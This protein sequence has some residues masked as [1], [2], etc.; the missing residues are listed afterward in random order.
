MGWGRWGFPLPAPSEKSSERGWRLAMAARQMEW[1]READKIPITQVSHPNLVHDF[2]ASQPGLA[3]VCHD[4][5]RYLIA[6]A[7]QLS[8]PGFGGQ[9][10][11]Q[12]ESLYQDSVEL[13]RARRAAKSPSGTALTT[14]KNPPGCDEEYALRDPNFG[15][16]KSSLIACGFVQG[17][18]VV[19]GPRPQHYSCIDYV[20]W[21]LSDESCWLPT[22]VRDVLTEGLATWA[23]WIWSG[24]ER[25]LDDFGFEGASFTGLLME[26]LMEERVSPSVSGFLLSA[27]ARKDLIHRLE[28]SAELLGLPE[29]G[30]VLADR[31]LTAG[32]MQSYL[33]SGKKK[34]KRKK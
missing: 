29:S 15:R 26:E 22:E 18:G 12:I 32:F 21:V 10:E 31:F 11:D 25:I 28:F 14:D 5:V 23:A 1:K 4:D 6:Y 8:I 30:K 27:D 13:A 9:F 19:N 34:K 33:D 17:H 7:P 3:D 24:D 2:I 20:A 16:Y